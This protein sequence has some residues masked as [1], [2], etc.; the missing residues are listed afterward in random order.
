MMKPTTLQKISNICSII[1]VVLL[2]VVSSV[3]FFVDGFFISVPDEG[4]LTTWGFASIWA[5]GAFAAVA[6]ALGIVGN[7]RASKSVMMGPALGFSI[8]VLFA[9]WGFQAAADYLVF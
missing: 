3:L 1:A 7:K 6:L 9:Y 5:A 8:L 2:F 4:P